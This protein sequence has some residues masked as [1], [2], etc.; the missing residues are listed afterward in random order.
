MATSKS[1]KI[2]AEM[3]KVNG[4]ISDQQAK[5]K[6]L[7]STARRKTRRSWTSCAA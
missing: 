7:E 5:L 4:K 3:E 2:I 6:E 1:A